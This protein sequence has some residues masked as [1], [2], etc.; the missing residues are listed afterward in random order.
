MLNG[1]DLTFNLTKC[2]FNEMISAQ[3]I[4]LNKGVEANDS[5]QLMKRE[6]EKRLG[7]S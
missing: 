6:V 5:A 1:W 7:T 3:M 2:N 4:G